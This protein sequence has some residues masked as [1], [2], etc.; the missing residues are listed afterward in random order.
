MRHSAPIA[1]SAA[2]AVLCELAVLEDDRVVLGRDWRH[3]Q[4]VV[5]MVDT[6]SVAVLA[7]VIDARVNCSPAVPRLTPVRTITAVVC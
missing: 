7:T 5:V 6:L 1:G 4:A 2:P 3:V